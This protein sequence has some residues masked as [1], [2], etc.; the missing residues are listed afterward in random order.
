M[1]TNTHSFLVLRCLQA[2]SEPTS[3]KMSGLL[4]LRRPDHEADHP[5]PSFVFIQI[6]MN[7]YSHAIQIGSGSHSLPFNDIGD[8]L[9]KRKADGA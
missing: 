1:T 9:P 4:G 2:D 3:N 5:R 8:C 6:P 7:R